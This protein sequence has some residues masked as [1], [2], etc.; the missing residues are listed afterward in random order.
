M[1]QI[2]FYL[3][4]FAS[5][6][7]STKIAVLREHFSGTDIHF[8]AESYNTYDPNVAHTEINT[9]IAANQ[10]ADQAPIFVGTSLG[11]YWAYYFAA[12][13]RG[14]VVLANPSLFPTESLGKFVQADGSYTS[15]SGEEFVFTQQMV[16][17][18]Q[19]YP[20]DNKPTSGIVLLNTGD[21]L[22]GHT[23]PR[24]EQ[25]LKDIATIQYL[26]GGN[27]RFEN[28]DDLITAIEQVAKKSAKGADTHC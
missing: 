13:Y 27:H 20:L 23:F 6:A 1:N 7:D 16:D 4:G 12:K 8:V 21:E 22:I 2:V 9:L 18:Y 24:V 3:H 17:D 26:V 14:H 10:T 28:I 19:N 25:Q 5:S 15:F 11:G